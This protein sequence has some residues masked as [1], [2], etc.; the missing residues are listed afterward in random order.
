MGGPVPSEALTG[1]LEAFQTLQ[2][3]QTSPDSRREAQVRVGTPWMSGVVILSFGWAVALHGLTL[4]P[5]YK[6]L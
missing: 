3:L 6:M 5:V 2:K 4:K 1:G